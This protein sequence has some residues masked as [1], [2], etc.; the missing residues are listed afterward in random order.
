[1][2]FRLRL[3]GRLNVWPV[4][5]R[6]L[7]EGAR[8]SINHRLRL[9]SGVIGT[10]LLWFVVSNSDAPVS[11]LG[12][13]LLS[14]LHCAILA[15]IFLVVPASAAD[16]IAREHRE[17]TMP[18]L[19]LTPLSAGGIVAG[20]V[21]V[22]ALRALTLWLTLLPLLSMPFLAGG[23]G[24]ADAFSAVCLEFSATILCLAAGMLASSLAR[25]RNR[26]ILLAYTLA[27]MFLFVFSQMV[28]FS[29]L[30]GSGTLRKL[31]S[32]YR[33][34]FAEAIE[35]AIAVI[36]GAFGGSYG[37]SS[38]ARM[39]P[40]IWRTWQDLCWAIPLVATLL[41]YLINRF[42]AARLR[43]SWRDKVPYARTQKLQRR[44]CTPILA[45]WFKRRS[46]RSLD[47]NPIA[48]LQQY[49]WQARLTKWL[50]CMGFL[51]ICCLATTGS[52]DTF[53]VVLGWLMA[54]LGLF[55]LAAGVNGFMEEKRTGALELLL[56]T[57]L[58]ARKLIFGRTWGLWKQFLPSALVLAAFW[59]Y[60]RQWNAFVG[61]SPEE[62]DNDSLTR[63][64]MVGSVLV[65]AFM[66]LPVFAS[67]F[68]LRVKWLLL[69][70]GLTVVAMWIPSAMAAATA[71]FLS[72]GSDG[73]SFLV[74]GPVLI[75]WYGAFVWLACRLLQH[76][77]SRRIY[78]F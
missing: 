56:V 16:C 13:E 31:P 35:V 20:K 60:W 41:F 3:F 55:Y 18:L 40:V 39:S 68:A 5:Q 14:G 11:S 65:C 38:M 21:S 64:M 37:W 23:V 10:L 7:R 72:M 28:V 78:A 75:F 49:S 42:A 57:P 48:W 12:K 32:D 2:L 19:F 30:M 69:A 43:R 74:F 17:G 59:F 47:R 8:R 54:I 63:M 52:A 44:F 62:R 66:T 29:L 26:A 9:L 50:L 34:W 51:L 76:S 53:V 71:A 22:Q 77:L 36:G 33:E 58:P 6:E 4:V 73:P 1:M 24:W 25:D 46:Q 67:Y 70:V 15:L 27:A 61:T 45:P